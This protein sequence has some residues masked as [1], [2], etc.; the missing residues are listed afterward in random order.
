MKS[1]FIY[2]LGLLFLLLGCATSGSVVV[3]TEPPQA[4]VYFVDSVSGQTALLGET[5][6][7]FDRREQAKG[8][9]V[10]QVRIEKE[11]FEPKYAAV[12]SFGGETTFVD[13]KLNSTAN[14]S[15]DI[16]KAFEASRGMMLEAN[17]LV[18]AKRF[19]EALVRIEKVIEIDPRNS[20]AHAAKGSVLFLMKDLEG[21]KTSWTRALEINPG[22]E[23][24][25]SSLIELNLQG[26]RSPAGAGGN[27]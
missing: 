6:L 20:E 17:R 19:S 14:A 13:V 23:I 11:G 10:I 9:D 24:V 16:R 4:K 3:R 2:S 26:V 18:S 25:R 27:P 5:P 21:A 15:G 12:A 8:K 1:R 7:T 22:Y